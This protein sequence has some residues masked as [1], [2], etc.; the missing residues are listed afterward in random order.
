[1][2]AQSGYDDWAGAYDEAFPTGYSTPAERGAVAIFAEGLLASGPPGPVV[3]VGCGTGHIAADL[4]ARDL[5]V[6]GVDPSAA[7]LALAQQRYPG[8]RWW[9][10][11]AGL[12]ELPEELG[13]LAGILARYS[14]IHVDP[15][16]L[17]AVLAAWTERLRVGADVMV[18]FQCSADPRQPVLEFDHRVA[19]AW[20]WHPDAMAALLAEAGLVERWRMVSQPDEAHRFAECHLIAR[21]PG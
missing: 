2:E 3:D 1:V 14:L 5:D 15:Q 10:G 20:R 12:A 17:P 19:R 7:M 21:F 6:V 4:A 18:A 8:M 11:D 16:D 9:S 13:P